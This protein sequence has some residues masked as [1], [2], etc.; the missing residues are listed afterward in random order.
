MDKLKGAHSTSNLPS[1]SC[2][3]GGLTLDMDRKLA[4]L[5]LDQSKWDL[6]LRSFVVL[7]ACAFYEL[8]C[9]FSLSH[10]R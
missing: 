3:A 8:S 2:M 1:L 6:T 9:H 10:E 5:S 4:N 7:K